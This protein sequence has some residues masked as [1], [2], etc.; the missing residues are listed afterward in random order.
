[1]HGLFSSPAAMEGVQ[2]HFKS[3]GLNG[4]SI[5]LGGHWRTPPDAL[6]KVTYR[7]WIEDFDIGY[8]I[9]SGLGEKVLVVGH[10]TGALLAVKKPSKIQKIS[11]ALAWR[12]LLGLKPMADIL[13]TIGNFRFFAASRFCKIDDPGFICKVLEKL[14]PGVMYRLKEGGYYSLPAGREVISLI[15]SIYNQYKES[16]GYL[17]TR[18]V[19]DPKYLTLWKIYS[20]VKVPVFLA[21]AE[22]DVVVP[23]GYLKKWLRFSEF[24]YQHVQFNE[25]TGVVHETLLI[26]KDTAQD[27]KHEGY[28]RDF[29]RH[30]RIMSQFF[31]LVH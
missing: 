20:K 26:S 7:Q 8:K 25:D 2:N 30:G 10:S 17:D 3:L 14:S 21:T 5:L 23:N 22:R 12:R 1:M 28:N 19:E 4:V 16:V 31:G 15:A 18:G 6:D 13:V 24:K 29:G 27:T 11:M 9:A